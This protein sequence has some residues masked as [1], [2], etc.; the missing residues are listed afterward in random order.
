MWIT[1]VFLN[2]QKLCGEIDLR[3]LQCSMFCYCFSYEVLSKVKTIFKKF[4]GSWEFLKCFWTWCIVCVFAVFEYLCLISRIAF[5]SLSIYL[6]YLKPNY[7]IF[8]LACIPLFQCF[9]STSVWLFCYWV[10]LSG[11]NHPTQST[12]AHRSLLFTYVLQSIIWDSSVE[13]Y[14]F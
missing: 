1:G 6:V 2:I 10:V 4:M 13:D 5:C 12:Y 3:L 11:G 14:D 7:S 8:I 9:S